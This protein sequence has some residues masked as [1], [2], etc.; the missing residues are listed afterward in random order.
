MIDVISATFCRSRSAADYWSRSPTVTFRPAV[1]PRPIP[2]WRGATSS[3]YLPEQDL[4]ATCPGE[5]R[6][7]TENPGMVH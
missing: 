7:D 2:W 3:P 6:S 4:Y 1:P 5:L